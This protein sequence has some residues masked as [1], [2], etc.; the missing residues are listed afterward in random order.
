MRK[1]LFLS[2][3]LLT[4][5]AGPALAQANSHSLEVSYT[6]S[7]WG[8]H[9]GQLQYSE[10]L[11]GNAYSARAHFETGG[12]V[13]FVWKS[14]IDGTADGNLDAH[15][16]SPSLYDSYSRYR[17][18]PLQRVKLT[19]AN[20]DPS[21][22]FDPPIELTRFPVSKEE[23]KDAVDPM[24]ALIGILMGASAD[25]HAPCGTGAQIF[26]GRRRYDVKFSY[27]K[28]EKLS[29][30][31]GLQA[32]AHLCELHFVPIAGYPQR[33]V[34]ERRDPPKMFADFIEIAETGTPNGRYVVPA[35]VWADL[36]LGTASAT[37]DAIT[38]QPPTMAARADGAVP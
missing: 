27:V 32:N 7:F 21:V 1:T 13:G 8:V 35:K 22:F 38:M 19:Y 4:A 29:L 2:V 28:D 24:S 33:L 9:F 14:I 20:D 15:H 16:V 34:M 36:S 3:A 5:A 17:D 10:I 6:L 11:K 25:S 31:S 23:Q 18:H 26:D 30:D 37:L 12:A